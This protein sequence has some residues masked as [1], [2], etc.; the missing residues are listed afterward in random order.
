MWWFSVLKRAG[1]PPAIAGRELGSSHR[2]VA[3]SRAC[4]A[5]LSSR[6]GNPEGLG[7]IPGQQGCWAYPGPQGREAIFVVGAEWLAS[8]QE[9]VLVGMVE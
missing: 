5:R 2:L 7:S 3:F 4:F 6:E 9:R 1:Q 8:G